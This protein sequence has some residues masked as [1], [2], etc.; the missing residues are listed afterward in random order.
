MGELRRRMEQNMELKGFSP[1]TKTCYLSHVRDYTRHHGR[2]PDKLGA[3][4]I[5]G[6]LQYLI[7]EKQVSRSA[8]A[9]AYSAL[10]F[11]Y[12]TTLHRGWE[13]AGI[14]RIKR[15]KKLPVVLT[16][17]EVQ[18]ILSGIG[19]IKHRAVLTTIY[20]G[21]LRLS[22][23]LHLKIIDIDSEAM[24]I[25]VD[26]GKGNK[27]RYTI[28]AQRTLEV[29]RD[30]WKAC[31][32]V[33]WLFPGS[34]KDRPM[35]PSTVQRVFRL[36]RERAGIGKPASVHTLRHCFATH[37]LEA[38]ADLYHIQQLL[39][40]G[41]VRTTSIYLHVGKKALGRTVSPLDYFESCAKSTS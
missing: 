18:Q 15:E 24:L 25:R 10:K 12:D 29:L 1:R 28:L 19:N 5:R 37:M 11:F 6:Y 41:S 35:G 7:H 38:G 13:I 34:C 40:H 9:Q 3:E 36:A 22:E 39:G 33:D 21:G 23:A 20:S 30:Y 2:A 8:V 32:P 31:Q 26:Q 14:P 4:E 16:F 27:D 17:G